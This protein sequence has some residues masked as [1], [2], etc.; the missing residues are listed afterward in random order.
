ME[1]L[2]ASVKGKLKVQVRWSIEAVKLEQ[3]A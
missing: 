1:D 3:R 2:V